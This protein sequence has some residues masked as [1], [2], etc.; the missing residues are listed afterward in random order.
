MLRAH[1]GFV[2]VGGVAP[3]RG[4][5]REP[6][7]QR[8]L[9][10]QAEE[11]H[12]RFARE[13]RRPRALV[14]VGMGGVNQ[15]AGARPQ[16]PPRLVDQPRVSLRARL[17]AIGRLRQRRGL[18]HAEQALALDVA[19]QPH[20]PR[21]GAKLR[22]ERRAQRA[23]ARA[24]KAADGDEARRRGVE[25][26]LRER[27]IASRR[28]GLCAHLGADR[29]AQRKKQRQ[30]RQ[31]V[32]RLR[33]LM[34]QIDVQ[35]K[36]GLAPE[37]ALPQ[38]H[39]SERQIVE[40]VPRRH[41]LVEFNGVERDGAP[42][43]HR[44]IAKMQVAVATPHRARLSA[45][46]QQRRG[47]RQRRARPCG[48]VQRDI[49]DE[50]IGR[51]RK[52]LRILFDP[53]R[54]RSHRRF[55]FAHRRAGVHRV[56]GLSQRAD[57]CFANLAAFGEPVERRVLVEAPHA[58]RPIDDLALALEAKTLRRAP[59]RRRV[60]IYLR[61]VGAVERDLR[62]RRTAAQGKSRVIEER[63]FYRAP[64][65]D[66]VLALE[67]HDRALCVD[68]CRA[69]RK[70]CENGGLQGVFAHRVSACQAATQPR[71]RSAA[72]ASADAASVIVAP[73]RVANKAAAAASA[74]ATAGRL[75]LCQTGAS[76]P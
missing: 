55:R 48:E 12:A 41:R 45:R 71:P 28:V 4:D 21:R 13:R 65:L 29:R 73:A 5:A 38:V 63:Q 46:P 74:S 59:Y 16:R 66:R 2:R 67:E 23:L 44:D 70:R 64:Y 75:T 37:V 61:R 10:P 57:G 40:H 39:Y 30:Q 20:R 17:G 9:Q 58:R 14:G 51:P 25:K 53:A 33:R 26:G 62:L 1:D 8:R 27:E 6:R 3:P 76:T 18:G 54:E 35:Q 47:G 34:R 56:Y 43:D 68:A 49:C 31:R 50:Q 72:P 32:A 36:V 24:R 15:H 52:T 60:F 69:F 19:A 7:L 11:R 42:V 22:R